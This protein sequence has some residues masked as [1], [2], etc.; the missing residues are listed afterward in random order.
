MRVLTVPEI[1]EYLRLAADVAASCPVVDAHVHGT[2]VVFGS[3]QPAAR[4]DQP[5]PA[6]PPRLASLRLDDPARLAGGFDT[7]TRNHVSRLHFTTA[8]Q[9]LD[10]RLLLAHMD[11]ARVHAAVL[12]PV[13]P[14]DG[15]ID[16][17][18][19]A[20]AALRSGEE[21]L[22]LGYSVP[23]S[24][25]LDAIASDIRSAVKTHGARVVKLHPN[26]TRL[27]LRAP[28]GAARAEAILVASG[29]VGLPLVVHGGH[30]PI[31]EAEA[32][33]HHAV[34]QNLERIDWGRSAA[35]VVVAHCGFYGCD[36]HEIVAE[37]MPALARILARHPNVLVDT[38]GLSFDLLLQV[39]RTVDHG[40]IVLGSDA[41]YSSMWQSVVTLLHALRT[42]GFDV[43]AGYARIASHNA[44]GRLSLP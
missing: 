39:L 13:A 7:R 42:A 21:R 43:T 33:S 15:P 41:V 36:E 3:G 2:E 25:P 14:A 17:Q 24:V 34:L 19:Q 11:L 38:S 44:R 23:N 35:S 10:R 8:Y 30:S 1:E 31:L 28:E 6:R 5:P 40:R 32:A 20:L 26:L 29:E 22:L 16:G 37:A 12:L 27:D 4:P 18:M 9:Q